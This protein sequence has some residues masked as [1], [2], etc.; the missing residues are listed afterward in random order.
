[1]HPACLGGGAEFPVPDCWSRHVCRMAAPGQEE[2]RCCTATEGTSGKGDGGGSHPRVLREVSRRGWPHGD[3]G[4][5]GSGGPPQSGLRR[6]YCPHHACVLGPG[7]QSLTLGFPGAAM[8]TP[9]MRPAVRRPP[10][11]GRELNV[12][13]SGVHLLT[14][15]TAAQRLLRSGCCL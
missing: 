5:P 12:S 2:T 14:F 4:H 10:C 15:R 3:V 8:L 1:M 13:R 9:I 7:L 6:Q 11:L